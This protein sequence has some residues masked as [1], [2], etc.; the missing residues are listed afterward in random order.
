MD[1]VLGNGVGHHASGMFQ[2]KPNDI[3]VMAVYSIRLIKEGVWDNI[4]DIVGNRRRL[5]AGIQFEDNCWGDRS[6]GTIIPRFTIHMLTFREGGEVQI[7]EVD[8]LP[9]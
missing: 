1:Y 6:H 3:V 2:V 5:E 4:N 7:V 9:K 8:E